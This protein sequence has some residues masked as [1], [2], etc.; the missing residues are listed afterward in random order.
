MIQLPQLGDPLIV[1]TVLESSGYLLGFALLRR[2]RR[3]RGDFLPSAQRW[4]MIGAAIAGAALGAQLLGTLARPDLFAEHWRDLQYWI[5]GKTI[6][7]GLLGGWLAV[8]ATKSFLGV[9]RRT[10][11]LYVL[12]LAV[13]I[14][15]GRL[16]CFFAGLDDGTWGIPT[17]LPWAVDFG[18]GIGR[19][20]TQIYELLFVAVVGWRLSRRDIREAPEGSRFRAFLLAY[21]AFR[22]LVDFIKPYPTVYGLQPI[23]WPACWP[24]PCSCE[25]FAGG[26]CSFSPQSRVQSRSRH[27]RE[28][29]TSTP[30]RAS[31]RSSRVF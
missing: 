5:S 19:H 23:Q 24:S 10:G 1:H 16:G 27:E 14:V 21:L 25:N 6:V 18:D 11:D 20:P 13:G 30:T 15:L 28:A 9:D 4:G 8:E 12:P 26:A 3:A 7:G 17:S 29:T 2:A 22:F 31:F